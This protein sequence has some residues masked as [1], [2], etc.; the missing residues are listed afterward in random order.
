VLR[1]VLNIVVAEVSNDVVNTVLVLIEVLNVVVVDLLVE[2][3]L[4]KP[5]LVDT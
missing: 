3:L 5:V 4:E 2:V 1:D